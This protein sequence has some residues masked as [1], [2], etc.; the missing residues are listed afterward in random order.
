MSDS[1][2]CARHGIPLCPRAG[3]G[4]RALPTFS[5]AR[6]Q[7]LSCLSVLLSPRLQNNG[8]PFLG[9]QIKLSQ[10]SFVQNIV[11]CFDSSTL[12]KAPELQ[13]DL[14]ECL[15][16]HS[17]GLACQKLHEGSRAQNASEVLSG[18]G[19]VHVRQ[20]PQ[21]QVLCETAGVQELA[22]HSEMASSWPKMVPG[23]IRN[24]FKIA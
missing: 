21:A 22:A 19:V 23:W 13:L 17:P 10:R 11:E 8:K 24:G 20:D 14:S 9:N 16:S 5:S 15:S 7:N 3:N 2:P 1:L 4:L 6:K 18:P 12:I